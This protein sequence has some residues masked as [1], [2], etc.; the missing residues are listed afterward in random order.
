MTILQLLILTISTGLVALLISLAMNWRDKRATTTKTF[1]FMSLF[2][3]IVLFTAI[4]LFTCIY[5][6]FR[7][8]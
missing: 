1:A 4:G 5:A 3:V 7:G 8:H 2:G 6:A